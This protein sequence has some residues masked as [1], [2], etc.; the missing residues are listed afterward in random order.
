VYRSIDAIRSELGERV[1][2]VPVVT[3]ISG[4][5]FYVFDE[6]ERQVIAI[7][8]TRPAEIRNWV[9]N[10]VISGAV[11][12]FLRVD[13][14]EGFLLA[15]RVIELSLLSRLDSRRPVHLTGHSL[16]GSLATLL[17]LRLRRRGH[18]VSVTTFGAP[19]ITTFD[20]FTSESQLHE[21][22]LTRLINAGDLVHHFPT[23]MDTNGRR[24]YAHVGREWTMHADGSCAQTEL[25]ASLSKSA[26][27][28]LDRN[29]P[30]WS[31]ADHGIETYMSRLSTLSSCG[32]L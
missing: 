32:D 27:L 18:E 11:D 5:Q 6:G 31:L 9:A 29:M 12:E 3:A 7:R 30:D 1:H 25:A 17:G 21:L 10:L 4:L 22:D 2:V 15:T 13:V 24:V 20:A 8:G 16:G 14:H 26:A 23:M 19:K 28:V